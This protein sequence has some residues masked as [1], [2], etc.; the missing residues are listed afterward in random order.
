MLDKLSSIP[1]YVALFAAAYPGEG[2]TKITLGKAIAAYERT[3]VSN[4]APFDRWQRGSERAVDA[5]VKR[6][7]EVFKGKGRCET[8]HGGFNFTDDGFHNIGLKGSTDPGRYAKVAIKAMHGAF[9]TPTLR[10]IAL[11]GPYMH[12]GRY[13]TLEDVIN[14]YDRGGDKGENVDEQIQKLGLTPQEKT[15][16]LAFM[17]SL[18]GLPMQVVVP[19][20]PNRVKGSMRTT[21]V[22]LNKPALEPAPAPGKKLDNVLPTASESANSLVAKYEILQNDKSF[23]YKGKQIVTMKVQAGDTVQFHNEDKVSHNLY[24]LSEAKTFDL[25][26]MRKGEIRKMTFDQHGDVQVQCAIHTDMLL[27]L[28][29]R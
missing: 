27:V 5:S 9:K 29:V 18:T 6:G 4:D 19:Q 7:F 13:D 23:F 3:I 15:D 22:A 14:H 21:A 17:H 26:T 11:T 20:L 10:D 16:L 28:D 8:C 25:G 2:I 12:D 24:S 1:G